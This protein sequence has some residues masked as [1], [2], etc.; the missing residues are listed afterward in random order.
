MQNVF[1]GKKKI[2]GFNRKEHGLICD[3]ELLM[4]CCYR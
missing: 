1:F 2:A 4:N 3:N